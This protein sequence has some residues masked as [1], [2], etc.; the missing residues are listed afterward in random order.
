MN[1]YSPIERIIIK[2]F[3]NIQDVQLDFS[4]SP[5]ITLVG[6]NEAGKSSILKAFEVCALHYNPRGQK[7]YIRTGAPFFGVGIQLASGE[8]IVRIKTKDDINKYEVR[9]ADGTVWST[10]KISEGLPVQVKELMG[11]VEEPETK[12]YLQVRTYENQLL[13]VYTPAS[14]NYKVMYDALK[15]GQITRAIR[16]GTEESNNIRQ[17]IISNAASIRTLESNVRKIEVLD[18]G[19]LIETREAVRKAKDRLIKLAEAV[20]ILNNIDITIEE[21]G[22]LRLI[23]TYKLEHID[24]VTVNNISSVGIL[25]NSIDELSKELHNIDEVSNLEPINVLQ[26]EYMRNAISSH[27]ELKKL[28]DEVMTLDGIDGLD[29]INEA[30]AAMVDSIMSTAIEADRVREKMGIY[31]EIGGVES[32]DKEIDTITKIAGMIESSNTLEKCRAENKTLQDE[33]QRINDIMKQSGARV[34]T[35]PNCGTDIVIGA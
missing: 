2:D 19:M 5:I 20:Q 34:E 14:T 13:L 25:S 24:E 18:L 16:N 1:K 10:T 22:V 28:K 12:E 4:E 26:A 11:M 7:R 15:V 30:V 6:D 27:D 35:C 32:V 33:I 9:Y 8:S 3:R 29:E 21:L 23:D 31:S 17:K